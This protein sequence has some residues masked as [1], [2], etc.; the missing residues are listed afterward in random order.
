MALSGVQYKSYDG[1]AY[2]KK[3]KTAVKVNISGRIMIDSSIHRRINPNYPISIVR[4][5]DPDALTDDEFSDEEWGGGGEYGS[6]SDVAQAA[7]RVLEEKKVS[8][9]CHRMSTPDLPRG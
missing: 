9:A 8:M 6:D 5:K 7:G 1:M 4:P 3:K 2:Y